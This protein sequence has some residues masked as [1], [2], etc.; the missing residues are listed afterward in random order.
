MHSAPSDDER[1]RSLLRE[2]RDVPAPDAALASSVARDVA[3]S[4]RSRRSPLRVLLETAWPR[5]ALA[6]VAAGAVFGAAAMEWKL[7]Q[8][9]DNDMP[10]RYRQWIAPQEAR[11]GTFQR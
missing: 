10:A 2:W 9:R 5:V 3:R 6:G 1:L 11:A 7:R 4:R 8:E